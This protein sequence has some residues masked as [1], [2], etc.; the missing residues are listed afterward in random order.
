M[1]LLAAQPLPALTIAD[2]KC[3]PIFGDFRVCYSRM[4]VYDIVRYHA[5]SIA[6]SSKGGSLGGA[7]VIRPID[8]ISLVP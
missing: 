5:D 6:E 8:I 3:P 4:L 1:A 7:T 2:S